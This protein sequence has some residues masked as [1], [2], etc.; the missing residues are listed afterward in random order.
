MVCAQCGA[1]SDEG[2][3]FCYNCG[4]RLDLQPAAQPGVATAQ[5]PQQGLP[6]PPSPIQPMSYQQPAPAGVYPPAVPNS[7]LAVISLISGIVAWVIFPLIAAIVAVITGHMARSE[8]RRS[9][10]GL[11][12]EGLA[13]IG[14]VLGYVQLAFAA[15]AVCAGLLFFVVALA[16]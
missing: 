9:G 6:P 4:A 12:G 1:V 13:M 8:I 15:L 7:N 10:G 14:L 3:R 11:A 16:A 5:A 2:Q